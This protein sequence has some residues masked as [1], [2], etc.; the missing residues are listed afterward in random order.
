V[1]FRVA[2]VG[3]LALAQAFGVVQT[4]FWTRIDA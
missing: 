1:L 4:H 3:V 2:L